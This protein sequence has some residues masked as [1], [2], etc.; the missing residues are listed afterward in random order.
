MV[1]RC[2]PNAYQI[3]EI[4]MTLN[5]LE[6][7]SFFQMGFVYNMHDGRDAVRRAGLSAIAEFLAHEWNES[8]LYLRS[9]RRASLYFTRGTVIWLFPVP[10]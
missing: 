5:V 10:L 3:S 9:S 7:H 1:K 4:P 6:G 2:W 8:Y